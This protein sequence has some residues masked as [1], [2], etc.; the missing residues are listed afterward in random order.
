M[1]KNATSSSAT[2]A[3]IMP[4]NS[5]RTSNWRGRSFD[6]KALTFLK[7]CVWCHQPGE[8]PSG[9][10]NIS[11]F[12]SLAGCQWV[13]SISPFFRPS[14]P[15]VQPF[16]SCYQCP[17]LVIDPGAVTGSPLDFTRGKRCLIVMNLGVASLQLH[18]LRPVKSCK[19]GTKLIN[20]FVVVISVLVCD[21]LEWPQLR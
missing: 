19:P 21:P 10:V 12:S 6:M 17:E 15:P 3:S 1:L 2:S 5:E 7:Y 16:P 8:H 20:R 13:F 11:I 18:K 4:G 14:L 9:S